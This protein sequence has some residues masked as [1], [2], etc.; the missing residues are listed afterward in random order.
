VIPTATSKIGHM[1]IL[2]EQKLC[3]KGLHW[4]PI[5]DKQCK[6]C[7]KL[8]NRNWI[9]ANSEHVR[10][11]RRE[12]NQANYEQLREKRKERYQAN[13]ERLC[14]LSREYSQAN[15]ERVREAKKKWYQAN[16]ELTRERSKKWREDN[17]ERCRE[18]TRKW[19]RDNQD[20]RNAAKARR[21]AAQKNA[22]APWGNTSGI[23]KFYTEARRL[24]KLTGVKYHVDH[25]YPLQNEYMCGLHVETNLQ[26]LTE[27]ENIAKGNRT[28]PGQL[29]CQKGSVYARFPKELTYLLNDQQ[30]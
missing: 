27:K 12:R 9:L 6:E 4:Y 14:K 17:F 22:L 19:D 5:T 21:R 20:V 7:L 8:A 24:T 13:R 16:R 10:E 18:C 11:K 2:A 26:I 30:T 28:W 15:P 1:E 25:I 23:K 29:E 3:R